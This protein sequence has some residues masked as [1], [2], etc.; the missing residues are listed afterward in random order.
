MAIHCARSSDTLV[1]LWWRR[2]L[3]NPRQIEDSGAG[4][5]PLARGGKGPAWL[6]SVDSEHEPRQI[7]A[8][9]GG[10]T[11]KTGVAAFGVLAMT[12]GSYQAFALTLLLFAAWPCFAETD[13]PA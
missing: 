12:R 2:P 11:G 1:M 5:S 8:R 3:F 13:G 10:Q 4:L 6:Q 7:S 9:I